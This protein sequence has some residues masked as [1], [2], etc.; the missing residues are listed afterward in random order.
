LIDS[1]IPKLSGHVLDPRDGSI[2]FQHDLDDLLAHLF[3][4]QADIPWF[5]SETPSATANHADH[6]DSQDMLCGPANPGN[7][8]F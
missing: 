6:Q 1:V 8:N 5:V 4:M 3:A 2:A 7:P